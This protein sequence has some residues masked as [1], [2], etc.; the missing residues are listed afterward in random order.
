MYTVELS[1][2]LHMLGN[3]SFLCIFQVMLVERKNTMKE[4]WSVLFF[5][6]A[7]RVIC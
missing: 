1:M 4:T 7:D 6:F 3:S 5:L 2:Y